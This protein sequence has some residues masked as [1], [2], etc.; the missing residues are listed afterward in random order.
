MLAALVLT[1]VYLGGAGADDCDDVTFDRAGYAYLACHSSSV[2]F[3]GGEKKDMDAHIVK[4]DPKR[5][6]IVYATRIGGKN[7]DAG[8]R[9]A[10]D[11]RA[12]RG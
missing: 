12:W 8:F 1:A 5:S 3:T 7:W 4:F 2:G 6:E 9:V 11:A 10:V